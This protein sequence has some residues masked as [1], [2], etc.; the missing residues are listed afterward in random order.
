MKTTK[1]KRL[2]LPLET[3][4]RLCLDGYPI[5]IRRGPEGMALFVDDRLNSAWRHDHGLANLKA[6]GEKRADEIDEFDSWQPPK[7]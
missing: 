7:P 6:I 3:G 4:D 5:E 2:W 1:T